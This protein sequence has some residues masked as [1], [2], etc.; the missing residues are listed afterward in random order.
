M[1]LYF[2]KEW[3]WKKS[4]TLKDPKL[5]TDELISDLNTIKFD[6]YLIYKDW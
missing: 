4:E 5:S 3:F 1:V 6:V 2:N